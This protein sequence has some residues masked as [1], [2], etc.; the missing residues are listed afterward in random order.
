MPEPIEQTPPAEPVVTEPVVEQQAEPTEAEKELTAKLEAMELENKRIKGTMSATDKKLAALQKEKDE[1]E[2]KSMSE[3]E[4]IKAE[5]EADRK[6]LVEET[7]DLFADTLKLDDESKGL[8]EGKTAQ[9]V[10]EKAALLKTFKESV[11]KES[12]D[13][14]TAL[15]KD[16]AIAKAEMP[17]PG[18]GGTS[19]AG[20]TREAIQAKLDEAIKAGNG[21]LAFALKEQLVNMPKKE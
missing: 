9:E 8:I 10:K 16:L 5:A 4:R 21:S 18:G 13:K 14:I 3:E 11:L 7:R 1:I 12:T 15:E 6:I 17:N 19:P 2:K 20:N